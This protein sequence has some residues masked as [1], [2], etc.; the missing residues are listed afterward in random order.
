MGNN[1]ESLWDWVLIE[2]KT[3]IET[4]CY[5]NEGKAK[6]W[7]LKNLIHRNN[8]L[9]AVIVPNEYKG[10]YIDGLLH[11]DNGLPAVIRT[12]GLKEWYIRGEMYKT[13]DKFR[14]IFD[15]ASKLMPRMD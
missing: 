10:W 13:N 3:Y 5:K 15:M 7:R 2:I 14:A 12:N 8:D 11:R 9:P 1:M 4:F 6:C